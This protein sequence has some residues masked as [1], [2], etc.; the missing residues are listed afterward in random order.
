M[1]AVLIQEISA[2]KPLTEL[3]CLKDVPLPE[4]NED[5]ILISVKCCAVCHTE[6][7]E[8]SG[9]AQPAYLPMIPGHQIVGKV[10][11]AGARCRIFRQGDWAAAGWIFSS[12]CCCNYCLNNHENLCPEFKATGKDA[13]GGYAEYF[14]IKEQFAL[15]IIPPEEFTPE[16]I[17]PLLCAGAIGFRSISLSEIEDGMNIGLFGFGASNHL[18]LKTLQAIFPKLK[19]FVFSRSKDERALA[20]KLNAYWCGEI[21]EEPPELLDRAIDTTPAWTPVISALKNIKPAGKVVVNAIRKEPRFRKELLQI[22]YE[23]HF[24]KEKKIQ[25]VANITRKDMQSFLEIAFNKK[26]KPEFTVY[27]LEDAAVALQEIIER[28][29]RGAKVLAI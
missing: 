23:E 4:I 18:V 26:I 11:K 10:E 25:S 15:K 20:L 3:L 7:D 29:I 21:E 13:W 28:K 12:C 8:I 6:L 5:E 14:K 24:W 17:A 1:K 27:K 9:R 22:S 19:V 16:E 2:Q